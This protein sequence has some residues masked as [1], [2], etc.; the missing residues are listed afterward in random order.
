MSSL[1]SC[2]LAKD[3]ME[4]MKIPKRLNKKPPPIGWWMSE[5]LDGYR[6]LFLTSHKQFLSRNN[7]TLIKISRN[8]LCALL[9]CPVCYTNMYAWR[10]MCIHVACACVYSIWWRDRGHRV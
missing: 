2:M 4:G 5:K 1:V 8:T 6:A 3:Y 10:S 7:K 9:D